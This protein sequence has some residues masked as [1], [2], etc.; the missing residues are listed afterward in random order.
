MKQIFF[1]SCVEQD[2]SSNHSRIYSMYET[3]N[4]LVEVDDLNEQ[5]NWRDDPYN[6]VR[7]NYLILPSQEQGVLN[8][9][10]VIQKDNVKLQQV[11]K[12]IDGYHSNTNTIT[13]IDTLQISNPNANKYL[14]APRPDLNSGQYQTID[15]KVI[16][17]FYTNK[18]TVPTHEV[19]TTY[20]MS[21]ELSFQHILN[22]GAEESMKLTLSGGLAG[23][24]KAQT[25]RTLEFNY[26]YGYINATKTVDIEIKSVRIL[27]ENLEVG[28]R[29]AVIKTVKWSKPIYISKLLGI[30]RI[31]G[32]YTGYVDTYL[33]WVRLGIYNKFKLISQH[34]PIIWGK[35]KELGFSLD[36]R[37]KEVIFKGVINMIDRKKMGDSYTIIYQA[38][39]LDVTGNINYKN[40]VGTP[41]EKIGR[42]DKQQNTIILK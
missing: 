6:F 23:V 29:T 11:L 32:Y 24:F 12:A 22:V 25:D 37:M 2:D 27:S 8:K 15:M 16:N 36:N 7:L 14:E 17:Q 5:T 30:S 40:P 18:I 10:N 31:T 3:I 4:H 39:E 38:Y 26:N 9:L 41:V 21:K 33:T 35:L 34:N 20:Q 13:G 1:Q 42:V 28:P 19:V